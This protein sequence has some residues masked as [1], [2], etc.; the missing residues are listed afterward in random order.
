[1]DWIWAFE[2]DYVLCAQFLQLASGLRCNQWEA[3]EPKRKTLTNHQA[4]YH[5]SQHLKAM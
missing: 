3:T 4:E 1:M 5:D 2:S